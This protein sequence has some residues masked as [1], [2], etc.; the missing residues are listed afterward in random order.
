MEQ[1][2]RRLI[3]DASQCCAC[4]GCVAV[5]P[6]AALGMNKLSLDIEQ[7]KCNGCGHCALFCPTEALTLDH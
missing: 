6:R 4:A 1:N 3:L 2:A 5:C 7:A